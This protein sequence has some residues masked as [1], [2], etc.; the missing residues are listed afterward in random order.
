VTLPSAL[1]EAVKRI[2][3]IAGFEV[4]IRKKTAITGYETILPL[5]TYAP[6]L[7]DRPFID[8]YSAIRNNTLVDRYR[9]YELWQLVEQTAKLEGA[10]I[11]VGVW[12][13]GTG[14]LIAKKASLCGI[15]ANIYLCDTFTG[16][17]KAGINDSTYKGGEHADTSKETVEALLQTMG[18]D[19]AII[20][21]GIFPEETG[22]TVRDKKF[23]FCHIDVDVY[24]SASDIVEW[25]WP[26]L[27]I[28]GIVV[29]DDYG[30]HKCDGIARFVNEERSKKD[31]LVVHNL[32]G[33]ALIVKLPDR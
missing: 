27:V 18:L 33:H 3:S 17:V 32:N 6:W 30:F 8:I 26:K 13:G 2:A 5:S 9:C 11:E 29:F 16:V 28:G 24:H 19:T 25:I 7:T 22:D 10:L 31:L 12:R 21:N 23:R 14:A 15:A 1:Y 4:I 20:L